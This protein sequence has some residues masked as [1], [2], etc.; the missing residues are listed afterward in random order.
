MDAVRPPRGGG[1]DWS[2]FLHNHMDQTWAC[3]FLQTHD[4]LFH[5]IFAFVIIELHSR[6]VVH[7]AVTR[8]P[9]E[10][11]TAQQLRNTLLDHDAPRFLIWDNDCKFGATFQAIADDEGVEILRTPVRVPR[12]NAF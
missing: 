8:S 5:P 7:A 4:L 6:R 10:Q 1:Q 3:D 2:T 12:A 11:W 9:T